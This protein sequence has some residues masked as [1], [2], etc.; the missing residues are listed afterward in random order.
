MILESLMAE[1]T[2][3]FSK[4]EKRLKIQTWVTKLV[5]VTDEQGR[6]GL[7]KA[8]DDDMEFM[9]SVGKFKQMCLSGAGCQNLE[10]EGIKAWGVVISNLNYSSSPVFND[11]CIPEAIR[12]M[13]GWRRVCQMTEDVVPF[14]KKEFTELYIIARRQEKQFDPKLKGDSG[15]MVN[16]KIE[17]NCKMIGYESKEDEKLALGMVGTKQIEELKMAEVLSP[18]NKKTKLARLRVKYG[19]VKLTKQ[20]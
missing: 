11:S 15:F 5:D 3:R 9:P 18:D 10:G 6:I 19:N 2:R 20:D 17:E 1:C 7:D 8:L 16:G 14:R 12:G 13:G 4:D